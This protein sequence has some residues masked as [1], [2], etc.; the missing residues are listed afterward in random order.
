[1]RLSILEMN[2]LT[3]SMAYSQDLVKDWLVKLKLQWRPVLAECLSLVPRTAP[4]Q[5]TLHNLILGRH[6]P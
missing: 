2:L 1:M 3:V 6:G 5:P 4:K